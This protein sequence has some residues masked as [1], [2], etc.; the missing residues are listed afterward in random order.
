MTLQERLVSIALFGGIALGMA[1][2]LAA[3]PSQMYLHHRELNGSELVVEAVRRAQE[4]PEL[5]AQLGEPLE[6]SLIVTRGSDLY[7]LAG[8]TSRS[9]PF[10][11]GGVRTKHISLLTTIAGPRGEAFFQV[12]GTQEVASGSWTSRRASVYGGDL[13]GEIKLLH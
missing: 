1:A 11:I 9:R 6:V 8:G 3:C 5:R 2:C 10:P 12:S 13:K 4:H 7:W